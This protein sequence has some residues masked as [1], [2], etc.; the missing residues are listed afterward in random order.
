MGF[1]QRDLRLLQRIGTEQERA[2]IP[3]VEEHLAKLLEA[4][5]VEGGQVVNFAT[6]REPRAAN[7]QAENAALRAKLATLERDVAQ[8]G[9][10][11]VGE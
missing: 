11:G 3:A 10:A 8:F 4:Q 2:A 7:L 5:P 1:L 6:G 9:E